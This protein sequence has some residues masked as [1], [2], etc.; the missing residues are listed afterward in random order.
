[1][2]G[3]LRVLGGSGLG[4][5][6]LY[7]GNAIGLASADVLAL[8]GTCL[9]PWSSGRPLGTKNLPFAV[10]SDSEQ[11]VSATRPNWSAPRPLFP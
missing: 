1:M 6:V 9:I 5:T 11:A 2:I 8:G 3:A 4:V 10:S 7:A